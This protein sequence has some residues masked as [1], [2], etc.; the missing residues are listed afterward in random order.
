MQEGAGINSREFV[1]NVI[2]D[3]DTEDMAKAEKALAE[4]Q[5]YV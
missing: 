3:V 2:S 1:A 4:A 5:E